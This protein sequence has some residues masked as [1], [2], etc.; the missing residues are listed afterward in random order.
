MTE[1]IF[2]T[3]NDTLNKPVM[4]ELLNKTLADA[5]DL[6][7]QTKY[8][9]WNVKGPHFI[10]LHELFDK[11]YEMFEDPIDD[12]AERIT[13]LGGVAEGTLR[14]GATASRLK[15]FPS[16]THVGMSVVEA[17]V[18]R[19]ADMAKHTRQAIDIAADAKDADTTDLL[20]GFSRDIDKA[21]W[22]LEAHTQA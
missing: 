7:S 6:A 22:F 5:L 3:K 2:P 11:L 20:T 16:K 17:L 13:Q 14:M 1:P 12:I 8:A 9:H 4:A 21:L 15:E 19:Y 10:A 18:A